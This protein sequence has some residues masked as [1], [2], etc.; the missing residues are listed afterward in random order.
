[1]ST[2]HDDPL[3]FDLAFVGV[4][5]AAL[6]L[7]RALLTSTLPP[8]RVVL[9]DRRASPPGRT[10]GAWFEQV[11]GWLAPLIEHEWAGLRV[12]GEGSE[13]EFAAPLRYVALRS[14]ALAAHVEGLL[15]TRGWAIT[16][17]QAEV[18]QVDARAD[19]AR[20]LV[21]GHEPLRARFVFDSRVA[22]THPPS[23]QSFVA[24][25]VALD[26]DHFEPDRALF[27]DLRRPSAS[28]LAFGHVLA[29]G[30]R[31]ALVYRVHV[32][33]T[34]CDTI[35]LDAYLRSLAIVDARVLA[36]EQG[37]IPLDARPAPRRLGVRLRI[38]V[39]GGRVKA[40]T[41]YAFT[42]MLADA[43]AIVASLVEH[44]HPFRLPR[45]RARFR[46]LDGV[47]LE[48]VRRRPA[49]AQQMFEAMLR[50]GHDAR[51]VRLLDERSSWR[52]LIGLMVA[53][54]AR[55]AL[56]REGLRWLLGRSARVGELAEGRGASETRG[57][58]SPW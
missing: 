56:A 37:H 46:M 12:A 10:I 36:R 21:R 17:I 33:P 49:L 32:G 38:G 26:H 40:S 9:I 30:P 1:M 29:F 57:S 41:G 34:R 6:A 16:R 55:L 11:P 48:V 20:I 13:R 22:W 7:I 54:P 50:P 28:S 52:E 24:A 25:R 31:E 51:L 35:D 5:V 2:D 14:E 44:G 4:G 18:E 58:S 39:A 3:E 23:W 47:L 15:A 43:E 8:C 53:M 45:D 27:M 42:R 19:H